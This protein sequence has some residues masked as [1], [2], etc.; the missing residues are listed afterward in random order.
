[1]NKILN[2]SKIKR[3]E[4]NESFHN[5]RERNKLSNGYFMKRKIGNGIFKFARGVMLFG[6]CFLILQPLLSK[7]SVSFMLERDLYDATIINIPRNFTTS[8]YERASMLMNYPRSIVST[9][10]VSL[11]VALVQVASTTLVA[12]GF[13]RY[14]FPGKNLLFGAVIL[15]IVIPPQTILTA[16]YL[17]FRYFDFF[18]IISLFG[19]K[20]VNLLNSIWPYIMVSA[21]AMGLKNGLYIFMLRQY[22]RGIPKELEEAAYVDGCGKLKTFLVIM[23]PDARPMLTSIFLF[24]YVWQ[25]TDTFY[26]SLFLRKFGLLSNAVSGLGDGLTTYIQN[27]SN[28]TE[29]PSIAYQQAII[30]TGMLMVIAP[31]LIIYLVAQKGFVESLAQAGIKM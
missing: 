25:W 30:S 2:K 31:L 16:L 3:K 23:L 15:S 27:I 10:W 4:K 17:N 8:N 20:P 24:S 19:G 28:R 18:G 14:K 6:L 22:F 9:L 7:I 26:S 13:A 29:L 12:Y 21:G 11:V 1:M 5:V